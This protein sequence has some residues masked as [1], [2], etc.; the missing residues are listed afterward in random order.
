[1]EDN[2]PT[3]SHQ[4]SRFCKI[5]LSSIAISAF[6]YVIVN[7]ASNNG[8]QLARDIHTVRRAKKDL[9]IAWFLAYPFTGANVGLDLMHKY[10]G[11]SQGTNYGHYTCT[12]HGCKLNEHPS[13]P[14]NA[15]SPNGPFKLRHDLTLP[16]KGDVLVKTHCSGYCID[17]GD[18][19]CLLKDYVGALT[20][21]KAFFRSCAAGTKTE[22]G[23]EVFV[24]YDPYKSD[25]VMLAVRHPIEIITA[26]FHNKLEKLPNP[27]HHSWGRDGQLAWCE[28]Y[29]NQQ[30][31]HQMVSWYTEEAKAM[32]ENGDVPCHAELWR[33]SNFYNQAFR[34]MTFLDEAHHEVYFEDYDT[35]LTGTIEGMAKFLGAPNDGTET[36][37]Y[38]RQADYQFFSDEEKANMLK[39]FRIFATPETTDLF[40]HYS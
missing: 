21:V 36:I 2:Q 27:T 1:M 5:A 32:V 7:V 16:H 28:E 26:R 17:I 8:I 11:H 22:H 18:D 3:D 29:D 38:E 31:S 34:I 23:E 35:D 39:F 33:I 15:D 19:S 9:D 4:A 40:A 25:K 20:N 37:L 6:S 14:I 13:L 24:G 30:G 12:K 10:T